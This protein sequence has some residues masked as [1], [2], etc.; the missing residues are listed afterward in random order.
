MLCAQPPLALLSIERL[1]NP[2]RVRELNS[3]SFYYRGGLLITDIKST[4]TMMYADETMPRRRRRSRLSYAAVAIYAIIGAAAIT[5]VSATDSLV[6]RA[7]NMVHRHTAVS[8]EKQMKKLR[9]LKGQHNIAAPAKDTARKLQKKKQ[10]G[11]GAGGDGGGMA[12]LS[13]NRLRKPGNRGNNKRRG[14]R[15]GGNKRKRRNNNSNNRNKKNRNGGKKDWGSS[16]GGWSAGGKSGKESGGWSSGGSDDWNSDDCP[17]FWV[18]KKKWGGSKPRA[19]ST[20]GKSGKASG[21]DEG[22]K[23]KP[24]SDSGDDWDGKVKICTCTPTFFPTLSPTLAPSTV[25]PT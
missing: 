5:F 19:L 17:C 1:N 14:G 18:D 10:Q 21:G 7:D 2:R 20:G 11:G 9:G 3:V 25:E 23:W 4:R 6:E 13:G 12:A 22:G 8:D 15:G 16:G 24:S